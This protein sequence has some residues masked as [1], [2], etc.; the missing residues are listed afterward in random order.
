MNQYTHP[1]GKGA[2]HYN[3]MLKASDWEDKSVL[4]TRIITN[5]VGD[6]VPQNTKGFVKHA[7]AGLTVTFEGCPHC[8]TVLHVNRLEYSAVELIEE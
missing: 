7:H 6:A 4:S 8:G 2:G 1:K 3:G 5:E